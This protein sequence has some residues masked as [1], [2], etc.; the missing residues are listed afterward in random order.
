VEAISTS[1]PDRTEEE[2]QSGGTI[3]SLIPARLGPPGLVPVPHPPGHGSGVAWVLDASRSP[4]PATRR[5]ISQKQ[6]LNLS[7]SEVAFAVGTVYLLAK[8]SGPSSSAGCRT[9]RV[10]ATCS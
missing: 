6:A 4:S 9:V 8:W 2:G 3:R 10:G 7:S 1:V 5:L